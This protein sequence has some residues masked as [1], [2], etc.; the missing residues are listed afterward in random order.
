[1][2]VSSLRLLDDYARKVPKQEIND[3]PVCAWM[4][5]VHVARDSD[6]TAEAVEVLSRET[7]LGFD[8][9]TRPAFRKGVS[10]PPALIQL[11]GANAV[12][13]FQLSQIEDLRPLQ[14][15]LSDA[16]V[17]KTGVGLIQDVKQ[18]QEVAPF[19]PGGFVD[20]GEAAARNEVASRGLRSMAAAF[21]GVRISKRAQCSN[22][23]NDV[24]EAYQIRY[25]ATDAWIS[26]E[27]Y[28]AMQ[29]LALVDPQL[30]AVLLDS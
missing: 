10:Y 26:R 18:L 3:L 2:P 7:V 9:E 15:L 1:M 20:V 19:T 12:Y 29:P 14:A 27:I 22:W 4:G 30:D 13:L 23:A 25:A 11:A 8:T 28:L 16:A 5:D 17:L 6:E 21:F 24:L